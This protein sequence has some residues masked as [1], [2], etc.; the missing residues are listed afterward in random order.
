MSGAVRIRAKT[1]IGTVA[2]VGEDRP[3]AH[4]E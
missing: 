1:G 2:F 3:A 4:A